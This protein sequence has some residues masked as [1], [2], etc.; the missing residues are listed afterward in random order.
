MVFYFDKSPAKTFEYLKTVFNGIQVW[1]QK[2]HRHLDSMR[3]I[4]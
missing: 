1:K 2:Y 4:L 3:V